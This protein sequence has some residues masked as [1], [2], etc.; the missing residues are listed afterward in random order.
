MK[1]DRPLINKGKTFRLGELFSGPG[2]IA[3][4]AANA[5]IKN[6][7]GFFSISHAW[8]VDID[9]DACETYKRNICP[10]NEHSVIC[11]DIRSVDFDELKTISEIDALAFG[12]PCNDFSIVGEQQGINGAFGPLYTYGI[13]ALSLFQPQWF[14]AENVGGLISSNGG[15]AFKTI[16]HKLFMTGYNVIPHLYK[17]EEYGIPQARHRIVIIGIRKDLGIT[18]NV[19]SPNPYSNINNSSRYAIEKPPI[20]PDAPNNEFTMQSETVIERLKYIK[21]GENAFNASLPEHLKLNVKGA[22]ISQIYKRLDPKKPAYTITGSGGGGTH[23]YHWKE[24]RALTNRERARLQ[25]FPDNFIFYG[26]KESVRKQIGMAVPPAGA[27]IIMEAVLKSF[28]GVKYPSIESNIEPLLHHDSIC[29]HNL[30]TVTE[31]TMQIDKNGN[32]SAAK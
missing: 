8:S 11:S 31:Q 7:N 32:C 18:Y 22:K 4:G 5:G 19:P 6:K 16:L 30:N 14:F 25:T 27:K 15:R 9:P 20:P 21:P 1:S 29:N 10:E 26:P 28:A 24:N 12:F 17:F 13:K 3:L 2:G 23:V